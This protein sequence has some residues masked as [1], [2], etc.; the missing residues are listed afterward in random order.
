MTTS[1]KEMNEQ[2]RKIAREQF[3]DAHLAS[4]RMKIIVRAGQLSEEAND[5][6]RA[7]AIA[8]FEYAPGDLYPVDL[9]WMSRVLGSISGVTFLSAILAVAFGTIGI[10]IVKTGGQGAT[11]YFDTMRLFAGA[12]VGSA[13]ASI[14]GVTRRGV[15]LPTTRKP[16]H[17]STKSVSH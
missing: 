10:F 16:A 11:G 17:I 14:T 8:M 15:S 3:L 2:K 9:P 6:E 1:D 4:I 7:L 13:G 12:I 5:D